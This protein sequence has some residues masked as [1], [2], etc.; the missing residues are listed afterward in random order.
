MSKQQ[1][2]FLCTGN[3]CRSQMAEG[4]LRHIAGAQFDVYSSGV[5]PSHVNPMA[6]QVMDEVGIDISSHSSDDVKKYLDEEFNIVITVCDH[7][8]EACP[9]FP[10]V[11]TQLHWSFEDPAEAEGTEAERLKVF[12]RVRDEIREKIEGWLEGA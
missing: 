1:V 6:I 11:G 4:F 5:K 10:S 2:L 9:Q 3:S 7:A 12:H 8:K